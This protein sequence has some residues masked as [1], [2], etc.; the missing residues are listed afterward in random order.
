MIIKELNND[1]NSKASNDHNQKD[2]YNARRTATIESTKVAN[3]NLRLGHEKMQQT[4]S[5]EYLVIYI[6]FLPRIIKRLLSRG[7]EIVINQTE[8][9]EAKLAIFKDPSGIEVRL[10][11]LTEAQMEEGAAKKQWFARIGYYALPTSNTD[12]TVRFYERMFSYMPGMN[13]KKMIG[14]ITKLK[15]V[16]AKNKKDHSL[17]LQVL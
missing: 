7:F 1:K 17:F 8:L 15:M 11:E 9:F 10:I 16:N 2:E 6:H 13:N 14:D 12:A 4:T 3:Q 5:N